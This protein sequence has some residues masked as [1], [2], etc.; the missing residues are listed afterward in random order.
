M[1]LLTI[2]NLKISFLR[3]GEWNEAVHGVSF[4]VPKGKTLGI[5]GES[6]SGKSVSNLAVMR[7][8]NE[9]QSRITADEITLDGKDILHL[10]ENEITCTQTE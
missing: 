6:G 1:A 3:D 5:V 8:L 9:K 2:K 7:L 4:E 10:S